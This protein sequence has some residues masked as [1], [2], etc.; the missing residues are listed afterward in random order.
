MRQPFSLALLLISLFPLPCFAACDGF[1][2]GLEGGAAK[3]HY[4]RLFHPKGLIPEENKDD[5][6]P[7]GRIFW[8]YQWNRYGAIELGYAKL[9]YQDFDTATLCSIYGPLR[10]ITKESETMI[11]LL[12][13]GTIPLGCRAG[14]YAL[15]GGTYVNIDMTH[16]RTP[17]RFCPTYGAGFRYDLSPKVPI[18][19]S[20]VQVQEGGHFGEVNRLMLG[21]SYHFG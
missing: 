14:I 21:V 8:G 10:P 19:L 9:K 12:L 15:A 3:T 13:K 1:Y 17:T 4:H 16:D 18:H 5:H 6:G 11:D 2:V 20:W 7:V